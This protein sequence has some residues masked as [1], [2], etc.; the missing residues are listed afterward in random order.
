M[1]ANNLETTLIKTGQILRV[2]NFEDLFNSDTW[3]VVKGD[4]LY[5]ISKRTNTTIEQLMELNNLSS[6]LIKIGQVLRLK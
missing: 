2:Q 6:S 4:T 5:N 3:T 1:R